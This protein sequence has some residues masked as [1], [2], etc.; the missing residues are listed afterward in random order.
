VLVGGCVRDTLR[1]ASVDDFDVA[2]SAP[3]ETTLEL[4]P[5]AVPIGLRYGT[6]MIPTPAGPVDVT[7]FRAGGTLEADLAH[8]DFT[9]NAIAWDP[10]ANRQI[11]PFSGEQ[12]LR[13]GLLRAVGDP[14]D[15]FAEDPLRALRAVRIGACLELE[16]A[17]GLLEAMA[18]AAAKLSE[19][20]VER[21][22]RELEGILLAPGVRRGIEWLRASGIE[23][24]LAATVRADAG[25]LLERL[26]PDLVLRL[27]A[28][29]RGT[30]PQTTLGPLRFSERIIAQVARRVA[31]HPID[32]EPLE[33]EVAARRL[34]AKAGADTV[35]DLL[36][37]RQAE[38]D[39]A[40]TDAGQVRL[41]TIRSLI[42]RVKRRPGLSV[43]RR[44]LALS[45]S[46]VMQ[47]TG[48]APGRS[49]GAALDHLLECVLENPAHNTRETLREDL[50][51]WQR[52]QATGAGQP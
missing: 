11:D 13:A 52:A 1:G 40:E 29:L 22:R 45:G 16:L 50:L 28:W 51:A 18:W 5:Q 36:R 10:Q 32:R 43:R 9:L 41:D 39:A 42:D 34:L 48:L 12:D 20:A 8:R 21:L 19:V 35:E 47:I 26:P 4:F 2:T 3:V 23:A 24:Q 14:R 6:V 17:P 27:A 33:R 37:L 15:R 49:V 25:A 38:L 44:D 7:R 30:D 46:E 31:R